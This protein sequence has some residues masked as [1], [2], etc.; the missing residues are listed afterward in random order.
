[1]WEWLFGLKPEKPKKPKWRI[2][3]DGS[4][5]G[6]Q[7][8]ALAWTVYGGA[9]SQFRDGSAPEAPPA[10]QGTPFDEEYFARDAVAEFW[11]LQ[12]AE[13]QAHDLYFQLLARV[14]AAGLLREYVW[15][16]LREPDWVE[17]PGLDLGRLEVWLA[18]AGIPEHQPL[19]LA[20][21]GPG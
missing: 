9:K 6:N 1:M 16:F 3:L 5:R 17:P 21:I 7:H 4:L 8:S 10:G 13:Y 2:H 18:S 14:R 20:A 15:R 12:P 11:G 19:T